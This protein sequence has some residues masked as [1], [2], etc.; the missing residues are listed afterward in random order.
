[1]ANG[2]TFLVLMPEEQYAA[3]ELLAEREQR[4]TDQV[5]QEALRQ[6][7][8]Q[9]RP[10]NLAEALHWIREDAQAKGTDKLT[11]EEIDAEIAA[12]R[13]EKHEEAIRKPA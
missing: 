1:M 5:L 8:E 10:K 2:K 11:M 9:W 7:D 3:L 13:R 4:T 6:Y 12:Y